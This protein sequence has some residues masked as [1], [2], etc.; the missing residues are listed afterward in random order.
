[1]PPGAGDG[2]QP[3]LAEVYCHDYD[4]DQGATY[5]R[6]DN[7][8]REPV[9]LSGWIL[10]W[11]RTPLRLPPGPPLPAGGR[12]Y[13]AWNAVPFQRVLLRLPDWSVQPAAGVPAPER[14]AGAPAALDPRRGSVRLLSPLA[15]AADAFLWGDGPALPGWSGPGAPAAAAGVVYQ[16]AI[17]E[18]SLG[19]D[20]C[21]SFTAPGGSAAAWRQGTDWL[22]RRLVRVGQGCFPYPAFTAGA[23]LAFAAPD[24]AF[25]AVRGFLQAARSRLDIN[26]YLFTHGELAALVEAAIRRRVA[27]RLLMEGEP[28]QGMPPQDRA[29]IERLKRAGAQVRVLRTAAGGFKRYHFN[30]AKFAL[31][32]GERCLVMS[33]NWTR[34]SVPERARSGPRGWGVI[35]DCPPLAEHLTR[36]F[37]FDW[38]PRSLDTM[39]FDPDS[40]ALAGSGAEAE[41]AAAVPRPLADPVPPAAVSGPIRVT[42]VL[43]PEHALLE[44]LGVCG[45]IRGARSTLDVQQQ[46][47][48]LYWG[49][50]QEGSPEQTPSLFLAEA[51]AAARRGVRVRLLMDGEHL[52]R[53]DPRD[54]LQTREWLTA[55]A[56][57]ERLPLEARILDAGA[58]GMGIHNK[59]VIADGQRVL[60]S[61]INWTQN[62]PLND[63]ELGLIL[64]SPALAAYFAAFFAR[65]WASGR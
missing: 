65:D 46:S 64:E 20:G 63:R 12:R 34:T 2:R 61:S 21:G 33:E 22:P 17:E 39:S 62:S 60:I 47:L 32:D 52:N 35:L 15:E 4:P 10:E 16:R 19:P 29:T 31:A 45:L 28:H 57:R 3:I 54:N 13:L 50:D 58:T 59:G 48:Q 55:L 26:L 5:V 49:Y 38:N 1:M 18:A 9:D 6:I 14:P 44:T 42:P 23:A 7:P 36:V 25:A 53:R 27:V 40:P 43:A 30:H 56:R 8:G 11:D 41:L 37:E 51:V 24:G